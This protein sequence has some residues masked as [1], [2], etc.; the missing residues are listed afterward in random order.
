M[1]IFEAFDLAAKAVMQRF[2]EFDENNN[3][4]LDASPNR[5][6]LLPSNPDF[7]RARQEAETTARTLKHIAD[8][9]RNVDQ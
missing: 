5:F 6:I 2:D 1:K 9:Y 8:V 4:A 3:R 7:D